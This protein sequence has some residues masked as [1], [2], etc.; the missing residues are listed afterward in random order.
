[1]PKQVHARLRV[2]HTSRDAGKGQHPPLR[3]CVCV[4]VC[5]CVTLSRAPVQAMARMADLGSKCRDVRTREVGI[6]E[7][8]NKIHINEIE[9]VRRD[10]TANHG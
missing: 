7:I 4:C 5:V 10:Y 1:M 6:Q 8:H 9:L 2:R 3:L